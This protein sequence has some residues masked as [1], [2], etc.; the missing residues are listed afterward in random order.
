MEQKKYTITFK[1]FDT[2][3]GNKILGMSPIDPDI[4]VTHIIESSRQ[5]IQAASN[6]TKKARK[7]KWETNK[8][9]PPISSKQVDE[10]IK[11]LRAIIEDYAGK[12]DDVAW[13]DFVAS[14][15]SKKSTVYT[16]LYNN[17]IGNCFLR[18]KEGFPVLFSHQ[19]KGAVKDFAQSVC[20]LRE[21]RKIG[22]ILWSMSFTS[23]QLNRF[24]YPVGGMKFYKDAELTERKD[25]ERDENG[26][27]L[28]FSRPL[29]SKTPKGDV[30]A[31]SSSEYINAP[32]YG[33]FVLKTPL[34]SLDK[35]ALEEIFSLVEDYGFG[36]WRNSGKG[37]CELLSI[38]EEVWDKKKS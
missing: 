36:Q 11:S 8:D 13:N 2:E 32:F 9:A 20:R 29:R 21:K 12:I 3:E 1:F 28:M 24:L 15:F 30:V 4:Y 7:D 38:E 27:P 10:E 31:I 34:E 35:K 33:R 25:V 37:V 19:V 22:K 18:D 23:S 5:A 6:S 17:A 14:G 16:S 26:K